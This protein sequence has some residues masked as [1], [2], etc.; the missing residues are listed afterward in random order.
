MEW[1]RPRFAERRRGRWRRVHQ[2]IERG[3]VAEF[4]GELRVDGPSPFELSAHELHLAR[5]VRRVYRRG[6]EHVRRAH[7]SG[8]VGEELLQTRSVMLED[9]GDEMVDQLHNT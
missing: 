2:A 7:E 9:S 4:G 6:T 1:R 3:E 8:I 5:E